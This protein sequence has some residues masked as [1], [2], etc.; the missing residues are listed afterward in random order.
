MVPMRFTYDPA[1]DAANRKQ[2]G[3]PLIEGAHV[4]LG[5]PCRHLTRL[6]SRHEE[7]RWVTI[8][9]HPVFHGL[10]VVVYHFRSAD[11]VRLISV[12]KSTAQ[13][14]KRYAQRVN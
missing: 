13:E 4:L 8:G 11:L 10:L 2:H 12:R 14:R 1:K 5:D 9:P 7:E 3:L 6:D